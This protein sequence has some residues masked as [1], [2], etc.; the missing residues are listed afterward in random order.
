MKILCLLTSPLGV[1]CGQTLL[2]LPGRS[3]SLKILTAK[4]AKYHQGRKDRPR[5]EDLKLTQLLYW[6]S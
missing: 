6:I 4:V 1:L 2:D 3:R 5:S